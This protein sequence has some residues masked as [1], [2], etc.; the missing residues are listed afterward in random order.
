MRSTRNL[1]VLTTFSL[2]C[3]AFSLGAAA[4]SEP[5]QGSTGGETLRSWCQQ[6]DHQQMCSQA[7]TDHQ[8]AK[9]ACGGQAQGGQVSDECSQAR[10]KV[11]SDME[12]MR[13]A[14]APKPQRRG[15]RR[16][17]GNDTGSS[18]GGDELGDE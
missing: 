13:Q 3:S 4:Q 1:A 6:G 17:G 9:S 7:K 11:K 14:G 15:G 18:Q 8:A 2:V 5:A 10:A 12:A 16:R